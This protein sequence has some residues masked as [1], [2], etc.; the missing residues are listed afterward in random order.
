[1][2]TVAVVSGRRLSASRRLL[3]VGLAVAAAVAFYTFVSYLAGANSD[4]MSSL[5][6]ARDMASGNFWLKGW[7][8][9]AQP[10]IFTDAVWAALAISIFG[11][12]P[13]ILHVV[14]ALMYVATFALCILLVREA[15]PRSI[16]L[17]LP[18]FLVPT[19]FTALVGL[20][21]AVHGGAVLLATGSLFLLARASRRQ[22]L[23]RPLLR[24]RFIGHRFLV[25]PWLAM[26][27]ARH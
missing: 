9:S 4:N 17:I 25:N 22:L 8:L 14:P 19:V 21:L 23:I 10:F 16:I 26:P 6:I 11:D 1:M 24:R 15:N 3:L 7:S 13:L 12:D 27:H 20:E 18:L 5:L 2:T